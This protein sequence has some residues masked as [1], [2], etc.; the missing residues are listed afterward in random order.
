M[1]RGGKAK[2]KVDEFNKRK[3]EAAQLAAA[4]DESGTYRYVPS[5]FRLGSILALTVCSLTHRGAVS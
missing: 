3:R 1:A 5:F 2:K 4:Q